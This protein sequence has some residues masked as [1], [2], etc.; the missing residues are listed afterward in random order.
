MLLAYLD[1]CTVFGPLILWGQVGPSSV[2]LFLSLA[3]RHPLAANC[4]SGKYSLSWASLLWTFL[5]FGDSW[6]WSSSMCYIPCSA[7]IWWPLGSQLSGSAGSLTT[8]QPLHWQTI[9]PLSGSSRPTGPLSGGPWG[10][11]S[12]SQAVALWD[13][14][15][16]FPSG[17]PKQHCLALKMEVMLCTAD[18][19]GLCQNIATMLGNWLLN[20]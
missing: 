11:G 20:Y 6:T 8:S 15:P 5:L 16:W 7:T 14:L 3:L 12:N 18:V 1:L 2:S 9:F 19:L 10:G 13:G 4:G 17:G